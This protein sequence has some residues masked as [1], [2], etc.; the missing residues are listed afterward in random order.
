M[1]VPEGGHRPPALPLGGLSPPCAP[2]ARGG[3]ALHPSI[4]AS[5]IWG[6]HKHSQGLPFHRQGP[7]GGTWAVGTAGDP[8][9]TVG[10]LGT[11]CGVGTP[12]ARD[13]TRGRAGSPLHT[14]PPPQHPQVADPHQPMCPHPWPQCHSPKSPCHPA[15]PWALARPETQRGEGLP[16][17][18]RGGCGPGGPDPATYLCPILATAAWGALGTLG[19]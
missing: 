14:S 15:R 19:G 3:L 4:G 13:K 10:V 18:G 7:R 12:M 16:G 11:R 5:R 17:G 2:S 9:V 1:G 6:R 8:R